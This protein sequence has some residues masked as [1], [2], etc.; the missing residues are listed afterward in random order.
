VFGLLPWVPV[1]TSL[2]L[3]LVYV[4][5]GDASPARKLA[6]TA[7]FLTAVYLQFFSRHALAGMLVQV[8]VALG[9][10][11]WHKANAA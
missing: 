2:I 1:A 11:L 7:V 9:L 6:V 4:A 3:G 8:A 10:A 5:A